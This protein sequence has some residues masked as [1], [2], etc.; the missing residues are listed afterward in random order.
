AHWNIGSSTRKYTQHCLRVCAR[1][2]ALIREE[3]NV[4]LETGN[5]MGKEGVYGSHGAVIRLLRLL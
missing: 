5:K 4:G 1:N 2:V 3:A